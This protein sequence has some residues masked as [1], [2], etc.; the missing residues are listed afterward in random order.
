MKRVTLYTHPSSLNEATSCYIDNIK[1]AAINIGYDFKISESITSIKDTDVIFTITSNNFIKAFFLKPFSKTLFWSQGIEPE[2]SFMRE[3]NF[4][5]FYAKNL[6]EYIALKFSGIKFF[7]SESMLNHY[8]N[9]Y[10]LIFENYEIIPCFNLNYE[11]PDNLSLKRYENPSFVYAGSLC[12]WQNFEETLKVFKLIQDRI[13]SATLTLLTKENEKAFN[14]INQ[15]E[16]KNVVVKYV[17]LN[18][19]NKE[20]LKHKYGFLLRKDTKVNNVATPTKMNSY[21]ACGVIPIFSDSIKDYAI[22]INLGNYDLKMKAT[23]SVEDIARKIIDFENLEKDFSHLDGCIKKIFS[24]YY[25]QKKYIH[26]ISQR[27]KNFLS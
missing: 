11:K 6:I 8:K 27:L 20:L 10:G 22:N 23:D 3:N 15:Y 19:L 25:N 7:V 26:N 5:K 17:S 1:R 18:D 13:P 12:I 2:E 9:K 21:L 14:I 4:Y 16:L 24:D